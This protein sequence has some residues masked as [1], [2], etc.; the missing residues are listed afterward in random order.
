MGTERGTTEPEVLCSCRGSDTTEEMPGED[1]TGKERT[2]G[3]K[4]LIVDN[5]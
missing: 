1:P 3:R 4:V 2:D 5:P